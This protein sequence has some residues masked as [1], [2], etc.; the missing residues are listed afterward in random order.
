MSGPHLQLLHNSAITGGG[1]GG[2]VQKI[3]LGFGDMT[4]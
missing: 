1:T 3:R 4:L 2:G